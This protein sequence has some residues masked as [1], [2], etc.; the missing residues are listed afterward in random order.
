[1]RSA[2]STRALVFNLLAGQHWAAVANAVSVWVKSPPRS[3][4][5]LVINKLVWV[6]VSVPILSFMGCAIPVSKPFRGPGPQFLIP[7]IG[8]IISPLLLPLLLM[9]QE[10]LLVLFSKYFLMPCDALGPVL[11]PGKKET[12]R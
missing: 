4:P 3:T 2:L 1:M 7:H 5:A 9:Q 6:Q 11:G 8:L 10:F 12:N